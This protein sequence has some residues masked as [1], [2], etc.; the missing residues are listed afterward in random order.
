MEQAL[1]LPYINPDTDGVVCAV[2]YSCLFGHD[3]PCGCV[4]VYLGRLNE[5]TEAVLQ[6]CQLEPPSRVAELPALGDIV[7]VDTHHLLQLPEHL[8]PERVVLIIDHHPGGDVFPRAEVVNE[9]VGAAATLIYER[10]VALGEKIEHRLARALAAAIM[11]NTLEYAAPST[12]DRDRV[13]FDSLAGVGGWAPEFATDM[14]RARERWSSLPLD[15]LVRRDSKTFAFWGHTILISQ[16]ELAMVDVSRLD[17]QLLRSVE[18]LSTGSIEAAF[19]NMID[20][21]TRA[22]VLVVPAAE[23]Q[24]ALEATLQ[25]SFNGGIARVPRVLLRKTDLIPALEAWFSRKPRDPQ[26]K[27]V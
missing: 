22:S 5:E 12:C 25:V 14:R 1:V 19:L 9:R 7:L 20:T 16:V 27:H 8:S 2:A 3:H 4:P 15:E 17:R 13:A 26:E 21:N 24:C 23:I 11:S 18:A 10:A 6:F